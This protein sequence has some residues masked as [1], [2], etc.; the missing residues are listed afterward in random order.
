MADISLADIKTLREQLGT[1]MVDTK[2]AL[3]EAGG[4]IE[5]AIDLLRAKGAAKGKAKAAKTPVIRQ[6]L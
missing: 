6:G 1:G 5:K 2:N 4:D 3:V